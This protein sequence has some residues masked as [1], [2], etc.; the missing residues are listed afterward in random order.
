[1]QDAHDSARAVGHRTELSVVAAARIARLRRHPSRRHRPPTS[2]SRLCERAHTRGCTLLHA[3]PARKRLRPLGLT[4]VCLRRPPAR[5]FRSR[6]PSPCSPRSGAAPDRTLHV[7][8]QC[9]HGRPR[10]SRRPRVSG[11]AGYIR[12]IAASCRRRPFVT[13]GA[14]ISIRSQRLPWRRTHVPPEAAFLD[15]SLLL[16]AGRVHSVCMS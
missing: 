8:R 1:V 4:R 16:P 12:S 11:D 14:L 7:T 3:L 15:A 2:S 5:P 10:T 6:S 13:F 9:Y